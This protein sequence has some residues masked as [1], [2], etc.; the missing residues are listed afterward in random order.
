[1]ND[2]RWEEVLR[3]LD[4]SFGDLE[5]DE[6]EEEETQA[7]TETVVWTGPQGKMKLARITRPLVVDKKTHFSN[8]AG[9]STH[10]E[11]IYSKTESTSRVRLYR[12]NEATSDWVEMDA[13]DLGVAAGK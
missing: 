9:G 11:Y 3:R 12:W 8:R 4:K 10:V 13:A 6:I 1:M 5:F 2:Q 7:V